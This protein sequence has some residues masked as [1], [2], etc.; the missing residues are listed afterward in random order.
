ML[1]ASIMSP[2]PEQIP[3]GSGGPF[4]IPPPPPG[5]NYI[6][7]IRP[8]FLMLTL[9]TVWSSMLI[10]CLIALFLFP[11]ARLRK[12]PVFILNVLGV[13]LGLVLGVF[14]IVVE[15]M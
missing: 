10:P 9:G 7:A 13:T 5:L 4:E 6:E 2:S 12:S 1:S 8:S 11:T 3:Q 14:N 15:V